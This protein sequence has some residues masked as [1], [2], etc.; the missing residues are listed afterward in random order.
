MIFVDAFQF[1]AHSEGKAMKSLKV[2]ATAKS[3]RLSPNLVDVPK[4]TDLHPHEDIFFNPQDASLRLS[5]YIVSSK[6]F[7]LGWPSQ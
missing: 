7:S 6:G 3:E 4:W 1:C 5:L 2:K